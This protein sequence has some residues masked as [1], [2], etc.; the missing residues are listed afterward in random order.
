MKKNI[1]ALL[2]IT[3]L[4]VVGC[5][6]VP[7]QP[8]APT[9]SGGE[10]QAAPAASAGGSLS[11]DAA[12]IAQERGLSPDDITAA[13]KTYVPTGVHD[14]YVIFASGGHGGQILVM[15]V[16]SMRLLKVIGVFTPEPWQGWGYGVGNEV[17]DE[18]NVGDKEL[19]WADTHHPA[20]S[21][22]EGDYD[23]EFVFI[24]DKAAS[25]VAVV[26]LKDFETKQIVKN[27]IAINDH[28]GT[29]V[30]PNTEYVIE[31]GQ[32]AAPLAWEYAPISDY[33]DEYRGH[34]TFW[35]FDRDAGRID[36]E[37]S[38]SL[39]LPPYW[40]DLCD[41]GKLVSEGW[42]FCNSLNA[43]RATGGIEKGNPPFE[44]GVSQGDTDYL[45]ILDLNKLE[46]LVESGQT[47]EVNG[48]P[49]IA[50]QTAV[51]AGAL[52][53][54]PEPKS[55]HGVD[56]TP[57]GAFAV[58]SGKLDPHVTVYSFEKIMET[59]EAEKWDTDD[60]GV[61][62]LA[63]EDV[64]EAQVELGLG[65]LHTQFDN[66]GYAYTSLF[67]DSAVARWSLG[68]DFAD[69]NPEDPWTLVSKIPVH[70][71]IGHL[72]T[73]EGDTVDPDGKYLVSMNKWAIDR[74]QNVGP[75]L[76][77]NFQL[78]DIDNTGENM[79]LLYD[80]PI[81]I[82]EPHYA[83]MIKADKLDPWEV[84]PEIGWDP[85]TGEVSPNAV[86]PGEEKITRNG[87][88]VEVFMTVVRSHFTPEHV[89][90]KEGDNV[91]WHITNIE[92]AYDA[93]HG[94]AI[95]GYN[96]NVSLEPGEH[97]TIEFVADMPGTF[98]YYCTEFC[99]ALHLE[100]KGYM[101]VEPADGSSAM[102]NE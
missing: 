71:N 43:E 63:L 45:H 38:F 15:G 64:M 96:I 76:P 32:Y 86:A 101:L 69:Q 48:F 85:H 87:N 102:L 89:E 55:P 22:T 92:R 28:G 44:A 20:L 11:G 72:L 58:V 34:V 13:L 79:Q 29:F 75:L 54:T 60:Y 81:G 25:R 17:L 46:S 37:A 56:I 35:K 33:N 57:D 9:Q 61:P 80:A 36:E 2:V 21:E 18:G 23:G 100:M 7:Q 31:G 49:V 39:E 67:L 53:M 98:S 16:P 78:I 59:I 19:R 91:T 14:E 97:Q 90:I 95:P 50:M 5:T 51:D 68:G 10:E 47:V 30:T 52:F 8:S 3:F 6:L 27:P 73:A 82:G 41:S 62:V 26:D 42:I 12:T 4:V 65:P 84:Y 1:L 99:S 74:F 83:Q 70:Y 40:Q 94:F 66:Q 24:N 77:Q 88:D 93:T